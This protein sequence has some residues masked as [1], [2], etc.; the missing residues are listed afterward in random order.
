ML[1]NETIP[2]YKPFMY[3]DGYKPHE[4]LSSL[5][6]KMISELVDDGED[7]GEEVEIHSI[8]EVKK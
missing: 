5:H 1:S 8:V 2:E 6:Q 3:L 7:D 4:I